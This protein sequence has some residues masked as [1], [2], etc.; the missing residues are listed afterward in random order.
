MEYEDRFNPLAK[1]TNTEWVELLHSL[2]TTGDSVA[3]RGLR[4]LEKLSYTTR[5]DMTAP[6]VTVAERKVGY[7]FM[8]A[9]S[10]WIISGKNDLASISPYSKDIHKFSNDRKRFDGAYGVK[11][12]EQLRYVCDS[13]L[14]DSD[15]RQAVIGIWRENP[16]TSR[17]VP[18]TLSCQFLIRKV[19]SRRY[20]NC[21]D[22]M[23][24][25]D[26]WLGIVYDWFNFSMLSAYIL[27]TLKQRDQEG[28]QDVR[29]G[30]LSLTAGSQHLYVSNMHKAVD[31]ISNG[32]ANQLAY[33][34]LNID[35]FNSPEDFLCHLEM[36]KDKKDSGHKW[37]RELILA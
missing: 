29:L 19:G 20:L 37:M 32:I 14:D 34:P 3:P 5:V 18:C 4:C 17:D 36:L 6:V 1:P 31:I 9:E 25:S 22:Y 7:R 26:A 35:E 2:A 30:T 15:T 10:W 21:I 28:M 27:L 13:L 8:A 12:V 16:R 24:S 23:R 11:V 33:N